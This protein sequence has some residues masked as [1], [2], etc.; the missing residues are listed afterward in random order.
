ME[1]SESVVTELLD[2][3]VQLG[4]NKF[5]SIQFPDR[6]MGNDCPGSK[7]LEL[8]RSRSFRSMT[9][10]KPAA[11]AVRIIVLH[12]QDPVHP[13]NRGSAT[14]SWSGSFGCSERLRQSLRSLW[15]LP[16]LKISGHDSDFL[17]V[18]YGLNKL[19]NKDI[20]IFSDFLLPLQTDASLQWDSCRYFRCNF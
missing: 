11:S 9:P 16:R 6:N 8:Y 5:F 3:S 13:P 10:S 2:E 12:C 19:Q 4:S 14:C 15:S 20:W 17:D 1:A 7:G 18:L